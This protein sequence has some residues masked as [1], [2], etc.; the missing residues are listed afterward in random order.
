VPVTEPSWWY[1]RDRSWA[2][3]LL[4]PAAAIYGALASRRIANAQ[5][6]RSSLP[7]I[8]VGNFT[9][10]GSG[11]TP[12]AL[13]I[14]KLVADEGRAPW[15]L[16][17]GYGGAQRG[18]VQVDLT[19]HSA[20]DVGDEPLLLARS[21]PAVVARDRAEGA[22][23]IERAGP[24]SA[25]IIMDDGLQN[26]ALVKD[27]TIA[28]V[29]AA[30]GLGNGRVIP[31]GPLR[32][33]MEVQSALAQLIVLMGRD[34]VADG[35]AAQALRRRVT[36]SIIVGETRVAGDAARLRGQKLLAFAGI[37]NPDR[38]FRTL[39]KIGADV[40]AKRAF[41]DHHTF[42]DADARALLDESR[43]LG[44]LLV[45]TEKDF[46]RLSGRSGACA[47][48]KAHTQALAIETA[49]TSDGFEVLRSAVRRAIG[50]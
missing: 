33:P 34:G 8:C 31:A 42:S 24:P 37:A 36:A 20:H 10:G 11:K 48:L 19:A 4:S 40:I 39:E 35:A 14:A 23:F 47:D 45:T 1:G 12:L 5:P 25:V 29:D 49:M 43:R 7:V 44:A 6:Y 18:P 26:P 13:L 30:R 16:S 32:A 17:R 46:V 3:T 38:F 22:R 15:F 27:L 28:V 41:R 21:F 9:A 50:R 2:A